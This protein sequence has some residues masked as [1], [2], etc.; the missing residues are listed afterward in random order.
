M[1]AAAG[2]R[3]EERLKRMSGVLKKVL[4]S[5]WMSVLQS[6]KYSVVG[7]ESSALAF[8]SLFPCNWT[9]VLDFLGPLDFLV[10]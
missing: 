1:D 9:F 6:I 8:S 4:Q 5:I 2:T 10:E 7:G 3:F